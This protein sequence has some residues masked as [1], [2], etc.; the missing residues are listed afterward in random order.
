M[1][2]M[3]DTEAHGG[4]RHTGN[5][6]FCFPPSAFCSSGRWLSPDPLGGQISNPQSLNRYSYALNNPTTL[7]DPLGLQAQPCMI[8]VEK[9]LCATTTAAGSPDDYILW[10]LGQINFCAAFPFACGAPQP[11]TGFSGGGG[12]SAPPP[13]PAGS[14]FTLGLRTF[15]C[16][17]EF[18]NKYSIAGGLQ[19]R[20]AH[21]C[22][23]LACVR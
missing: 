18:A 17:S 15:T 14:A 2:E 1:I 11:T 12:G 3:T 9:G 5:S 16:A 7:T 10:P 8:G 6:A 21:T 13:A 4:R 19:A 20:V 23:R 22:R